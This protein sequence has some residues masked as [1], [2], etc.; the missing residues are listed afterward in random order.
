MAKIERF[1]VSF[2]IIGLLSGC[3]TIQGD[4]VP[5][6]TLNQPLA[7]PKTRQHRENL[8]GQ[9]HRTQPTSQGGTD[10]QIAVLHADGTYIFWF[11]Q[12]SSNGT[13][14]EFGEAGY[15][16]VSG[17]IH[18]TITQ[19]FMEDGQIFPANPEDP[20]NYLAYKILRLSDDIFTY[21]TLVTGN[22]FT[23]KRLNDG[24]YFGNPDEINS[25]FQAEFR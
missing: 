7:P 11:K 15:W 23:M 1:Y 8:I 18:F 3:S 9:W 12:T 5:A 20:T 17:N 13:V 21:Q 16:G 22:V 25:T 6:V 24:Q 14:D 4:H 19:A 2:I 10:S